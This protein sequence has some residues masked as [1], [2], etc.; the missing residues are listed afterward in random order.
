MNKLK[1]L[2]LSI[3]V[4]FA[5]GCASPA[6]IENMVY[7]PQSPLEY[8][9]GLKNE[10][11]VKTTSGGDKTNPLWTS[12]ISGEAFSAAV[13]SSLE[14]EGLLSDKG[15]YHLQIHMRETDQPMFGMNLTVT[16]HVNYILTDSMNNSIV[17]NE[18]IVAPYTATVGDSFA[19]VKRLRLANEG[20]GK[21][22]IKGL[23]EKL[24]ELKI[25]SN[26]VSVVK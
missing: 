18:T 13:K 19:A 8:D 23:L 1:W 3:P 12:E 14:S 24:S 22:N 25:N 5:F 15:R 6:K 20:S 2:L 4:V 16:T 10:V 7:H 21:M 17:L 9:R 26:E 11:D